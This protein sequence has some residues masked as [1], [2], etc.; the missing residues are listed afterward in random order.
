VAVVLRDRPGELLALFTASAGVNIED[1]RIDHA[2]HQP[3]GVV[4]LAVLPEAAA[5]L[6]RAL[7]AAGWEC[8]VKST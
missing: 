1:L 3:T 8:S 5:D 7:R 2:P 6:A 4:D